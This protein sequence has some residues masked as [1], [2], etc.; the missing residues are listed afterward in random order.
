[1]YLPAPSLSYVLSNRLPVKAMIVWLFYLIALLLW[2][3]FKFSSKKSNQLIGGDWLAAV[4]SGLY[5]SF[6]TIPLLGDSTYLIQI[7]QRQL[8]IIWA[9]EPVSHWLLTDTFSPYFLSEFLPPIMG[10][11]SMWLWLKLP[12]TRIELNRPQNSQRSFI[13]LFRILFFC[14]SPIQMIFYR[15]YFETLMIFVPLSLFYI[16][17]L[18][19]FAAK[20][21]SASS[22][23]VAALVL[24]I[25]MS[26]HGIGFV[27]LPILPVWLL[28]R[29][30]FALSFVALVIP[31]FVYCFFLA[32][33]W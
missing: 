28:F 19:T 11:V 33:F 10:T 32:L 24:G 18:L 8:K 25:T 15:G 4:I 3:K 16:H 30:R 29:R 26:V 6:Q 13:V 5:F 20:V 22:V 14:S 1:M 21:E 7:W 27:W 17:S 2:H 31:I 9:S 12:V 23:V